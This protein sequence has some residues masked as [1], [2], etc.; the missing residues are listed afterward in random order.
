M[1]Q[2]IR[3]KSCPFVIYDLACVTRYYTELTDICNKFLSLAQRLSLVVVWILL[4]KTSLLLCSF[5]RVNLRVHIRGLMILKRRCLMKSLIAHLPL[6]QTTMCLFIVSLSLIVSFL[7]LFL[8]CF[9]I[10]RDNFTLFG[11]SI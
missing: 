1:L 10:D 8:A 4:C 5:V 2:C 7:A 9:G 3:N 11:R 6:I